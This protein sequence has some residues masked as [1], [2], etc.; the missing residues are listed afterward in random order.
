MASAV[1]NQPYPGDKYIALKAI[2]EIFGRG[3]ENEI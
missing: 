3:K 1:G 2:K